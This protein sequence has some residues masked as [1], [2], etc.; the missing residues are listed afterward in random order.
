MYDKI[1]CFSPKGSKLLEKTLLT[2]VTLKYKVEA[3]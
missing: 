3:R 2:H 1:R